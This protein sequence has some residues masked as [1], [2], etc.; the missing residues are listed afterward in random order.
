MAPRGPLSPPAAGAKPKPVWK[1]LGLLL[2]CCRPG[3]GVREE[4]GEI[5][6]DSLLS[7]EMPSQGGPWHP[8]SV[9]EWGGGGAPF[10]PQT[11]SRHL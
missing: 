8:C 7:E 2:V 5:G 10:C 1:G 9:R 4:P 6:F 11:V 3:S